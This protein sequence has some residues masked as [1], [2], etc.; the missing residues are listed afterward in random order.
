MLKVE[1]K[2][3]ESAKTEKLPAQETE[4]NGTNSNVITGECRDES[5]EGLFTDAIQDGILSFAGSGRLSDNFDLYC[6][7]KVV[8]GHYCFAK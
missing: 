5:G 8:R 4:G 6:L 2:K 7:Q 3:P 1:C